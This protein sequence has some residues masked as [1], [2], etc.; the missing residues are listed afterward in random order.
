MSLRPRDIALV[1]SIL[2]NVFLIGAAVT[3]F[4]LHVKGIPVAGGERSSMRAA[5]LSL[6]KAQRAT[7][8]RLLH[9]QGQAI[10]AETRSAKAI[11]DDAWASL[12]SISFDPAVTKRRLAQ[13]RELNVLAHSR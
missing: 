3:I 5:A 2:I 12:A 9:T 6:D 13:A 1:I 7:F 10:Q 4:T 8:M 11:R